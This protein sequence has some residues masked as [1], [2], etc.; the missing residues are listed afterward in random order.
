LLL[1]PAIAF[2]LALWLNASHFVAVR[3]VWPRRRQVWRRRPKSASSTPFSR[4]RA[5]VA[6]GV[7][8]L[9][10]S[11]VEPS[12]QVFLGANPQTWAGPDLWIAAAITTVVCGALATVVSAP[13]TAS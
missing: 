3:D 7:F 13:G 10:L 2:D 8:G 9:V 5:L 1:A 6:G 4:G 11:L 12:Y